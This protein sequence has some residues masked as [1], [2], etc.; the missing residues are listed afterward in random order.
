MGLSTPTRRCVVL[1]KCI[2]YQPVR[3]WVYPAP[4]FE[5]SGFVTMKAREGLS[6][7]VALLGVDIYF[8]LRIA[9]FDL[10]ICVCPSHTGPS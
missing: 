3:A 9:A 7:L 6:G 2:I 8:V 4:D 10:C 1:A 5:E